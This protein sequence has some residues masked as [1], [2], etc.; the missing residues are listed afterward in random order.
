MNLLCHKGQS[1]T[2]QLFWLTKESLNRVGSY[3]G[4]GTMVNLLA[5][6]EKIKEA[7]ILG[8]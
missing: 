6:L 1:A 4:E 7:E 8:S 5:S 3:D 2:S